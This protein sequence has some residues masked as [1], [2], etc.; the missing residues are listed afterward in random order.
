MNRTPKQ[1]EN[2]RKEHYDKIYSR[3]HQL[4]DRLFPLLNRSDLVEDF[5]EPELRS[6]KTLE[7]KGR[8]KGLEKREKRTLGEVKRLDRKPTNKKISEVRPDLLWS[9]R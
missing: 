3:Q 6:N 5:L 9:L 4:M 7:N 8:R 1:L 2:I